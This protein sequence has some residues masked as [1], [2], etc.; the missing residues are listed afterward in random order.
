MGEGG[1]LVRTIRLLAATPK[2]K[3]PK[4]SDFWFLLFGHLMTEF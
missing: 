3:V 1:F 2:T 4:L